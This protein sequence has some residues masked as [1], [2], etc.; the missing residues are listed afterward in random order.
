MNSTVDTPAAGC[1]AHNLDNTDRRKT[2]KL[3]AAM[4][5]ATEGTH[6]VKD[7]GV[8]RRVMRS[9]H[10]LQAGASADML[11]YS[12]PEWMP[13][14]FL[15]GELHAKKRR[16]SLRFLS[17][18]AVSEKHF[19]VMRR[20]TDELLTEFRREGHVKLEDLSFR[21]AVEVV[22]VVLGLTESSQAGRVRRIQWVL[23]SSISNAPNNALS[24]FWLNFKRAF[25]TGLFYLFDVRPAI[26][27]RK[28]APRDDAIS[29]Y[30]D[31]EYPTTAIVVECLTYGTAGM[32]TT[33]EFI[34]MAAWY[35]FE[36]EALRARFL[37]GDEKEQ[38]AILMEIVRLEPIAAK[39]LRR[40]EEE[41]EG[42]ED[43]PLPPGE[44]YDIDIRNLNVH[45]D[46]VGECPFALDPER[47]QK[48]KDSGR[49]FSFGDGPH[50]CPGSQVALQETRIFLEQLFQVP[51]LKLEREPDISW[52][53][54]VHGYELRNA[55]ISCD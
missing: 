43:K 23:H 14:F 25:F 7:P 18:K 41:V 48:Q 30:L 11:N 51:G 28:E 13:V 16:N 9:K 10:A 12:N 54:M 27:S 8:A 35:L 21:L 6:W 42:L 49:F 32:L 19:A 53:D 50:G 47:A 15:D 40:V 31:L 36:D 55:E 4:N 44:K 38:L 2:A 34:I 5:H 37:G 22:G 24:R 33:R 1:P 3:A 26:K 45:E 39:L 29:T 52:N 17:P 20:V 46:L